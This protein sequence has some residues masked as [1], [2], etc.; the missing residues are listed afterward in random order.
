[1]TR[2]FWA[3]V[4]FWLAYLLPP[5]LIISVY[6]RGW[7]AVVPVV[8]VFV[9]LP[10]VDSISGIASIPREAPGIAFNRWFRLV[11]WLWV[12]TQI[13]VLFWLVRTVAQ[14]H[15]T[16]G[17]MIAS[18]CS[19]GAVTGAIGM[20]FAHE[21][22]HRRK[23]YERL[24]GNILLLTMTYPHFAIEHVKGHHRYVGTPRDPATA[25]LG[26]SIYRFLPRTVFGGARSAWQIERSRLAE[27]GTSV[28]SPGNVML[29]YAVAQVAIYAGIAAAFGPIA[30][31]MFA[32]QSLLAIAILEIIN[33][34]EHYGLVRKKT[35]ATEYERI[36]AEHSWDSG[37][38]VSNWLLINLPRHSDHHLTAAKRY[39]SLELLRHAPRLPAGYGAMFWLAL[40]PPLWF[41]AMN[42]RVAAARGTAPI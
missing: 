24:L 22:I 20:T 41:R 38:R 32:G 11:T 9:V 37:N 35:T 10:I 27:R 7:F 12:P 34:V 31:A 4:P 16:V 13:T 26:E 18:T 29:R 17:E 5:I 8:V 23:G 19:V 33:Y 25:R 14:A 39:Q 2:S 1:M 28:W 36:S 15:L 30:L 40:V 6:H 21:L 3:T 42:P